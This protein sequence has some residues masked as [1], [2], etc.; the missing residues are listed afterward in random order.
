M[1]LNLTGETVHSESGNTT[2]D[3]KKKFRPIIWSDHKPEV[4]LTVIISLGFAAFTLLHLV[5]TQTLFRLLRTDNS[6]QLIYKEVRNYLWSI[7]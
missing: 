1:E 2:T 3:E 6:L 5:T 4:I 7:V